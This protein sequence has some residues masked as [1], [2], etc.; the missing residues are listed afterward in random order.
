MNRTTTFSAIALAFALGGAAAHLTEAASA[1]SPAVVA[2][3]IDL[4]GLQPT[5]FPSPNPALPNI[6][7]KVLALVGTSQFAYS[8]GQSPKHTH[9]AT[10][11][12]QLVLGGTGTEWLGDKQIPVAPGTFVVIPPNTPH[13]GFTGGPFRLYTVKTP[14]QD[15][16]DYHSVP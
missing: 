2:T 13:G 3:A 7:T 15:P 14:P 8:V 1:A 11:E 6:R 5:E 10:T 9:A 16:T 4:N 12:V